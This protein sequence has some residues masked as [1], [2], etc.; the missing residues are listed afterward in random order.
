MAVAAS[1]A[2]IITSPLLPSSRCV[3]T[4]DPVPLVSDDVDAGVDVGCEEDGC[5]GDEDVFPP[6]GGGKTL[7]V[8]G[9]GGGGVALVVRGWLVVGVD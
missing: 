3:S 4:N 6:V 9:G 7:P 2:A 1:S 8:F 5:D